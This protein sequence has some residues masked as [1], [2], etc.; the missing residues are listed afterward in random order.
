MRTITTTLLLATSAMLLIGL[1][2]CGDF[3]VE[4]AC[5]VIEAPWPLGWTSSESRGACY[6]TDG[7]P[8]SE[9]CDPFVEECLCYPAGVYGFAIEHGDSPAYRYVHITSARG[10]NV[11]AVYTLTAEGVLSM[12]P[13]AQPLS[14]VCALRDEALADF[15]G[16]ELPPITSGDIITLR[17]AEGCDQALDPVE[18]LLFEARGGPG[19]AAA[20]LGDGRFV[21]P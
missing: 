20:P 2:A 18:V 14:D 13:T 21:V 12:S 11:G 15:T 19:I 8:G 9:A 10:V 16:P 1:S 4:P 5:S 6:C 3:D 7:G 17:H